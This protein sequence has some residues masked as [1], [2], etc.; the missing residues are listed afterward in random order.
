VQKEDGVKITEGSLRTKKEEEQQA[1][2]EKTY[3]T[4]TSHS[5]KKNVPQGLVGG[6]SRK[7]TETGV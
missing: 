2:K 6:P 5:E 4:H 7:N 3:G 1:K